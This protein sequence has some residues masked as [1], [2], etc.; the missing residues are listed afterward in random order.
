MI[1]VSGML[2][3][4]LIFISRGVYKVTFAVFKG[5]SLC[6][7]LCHPKRIASENCMPCDSHLHSYENTVNENRA[8]KKNKTDVQFYGA[9]IMQSDT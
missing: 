2:Y 4:L 7:P 9:R 8:K 6:Y 3:C 1:K 5:K